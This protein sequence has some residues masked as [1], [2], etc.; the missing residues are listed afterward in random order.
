MGISIE[1]RSLFAN[2][3]L[4]AKDFGVR[5]A[6]LFALQHPERVAG[7]ITVGIPYIPPAPSTFHTHLPEGFYISRWQETGRAEADF[8]RFDAKT[9][10][11]KIY[12]MF[13]RSEIPIAKENEEIMDLVGPE[14][15]LPSWFS[16]E[17]LAN[18]GSLYEKSGFQTALQL[19]YR[20]M[21]EEYDIPDP[22][23]KIP[24]LTIM[25]EEDYFLK[26]PGI[27]DYIN[28][29]KLKEFAPESEI[30]F[31]PQGTHFAHEQLPQVVNKLILNFL[32][33]HTRR[34]ESN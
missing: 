19:P 11:R 24:L 20:S 22:V 9:V 12:T 17:D 31:L 33:N 1:D 27:Q 34:L 7:V 8:G 15:P 28:S 26:F 25:G 16:E 21:N 5:P 13:S 23:L 29:G 6:Y 30:I 32:C 2:A 3:F 14:T 18:Y 4:I 10:V